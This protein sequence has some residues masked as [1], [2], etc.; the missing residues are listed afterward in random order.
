MRLKIESQF[1]PVLCPSWLSLPVTE[2]DS[3]EYFMYIGNLELN[4][5]P[6]SLIELNLLETVGCVLVGFSD[7]KGNKVYSDEFFTLKNNSLGK[8][9][10]YMFKK[11][12]NITRI[13]QEMNI[14]PIIYNPNFFIQHSDPMAQPNI[15]CEKC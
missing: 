9:I 7:H 1:H 14:V 15:I 3:E 2:W 13:L 4:V 11:D 8:Y 5:N 12:G 6:Y 10:Y